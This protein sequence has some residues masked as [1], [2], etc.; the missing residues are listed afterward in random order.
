MNKKPAYIVL[1]SIFFAILAFMFPIQIAFI[2]EL[3]IS[4]FEL[5]ISKLTYINILCMISLIIGGVLTFTMNKN[6]FFYLPI[7]N[8]FIFINNFVVAEYGQVYSHTITGIASLLFLSLTLGFYH[9]TIY[10]IYHDVKFRY[11]LT[12]PRTKKDL[13]VFIEYGDQ[14]YR[15]KTY[16]ISRSGIFIQASR[17][18]EMYSIPQNIKLTVRLYTNKKSYINL[19]AVIVRKGS[20]TGTYPSGLGL[21]LEKRFKDNE[22]NEFL[23]LPKIA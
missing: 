20:K 18:E 15:G 2:Y 7:L 16:D 9:R 4:D 12:S 8:F 17:D 10:K 19:E 22:F 5:I 6:I 1:M 21:K 11:W 23:Q 13:D 3:N 14:A